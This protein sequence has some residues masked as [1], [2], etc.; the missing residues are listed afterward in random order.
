M[1]NKKIFGEKSID[2]K[3][4]LI[5]VLILAFVLLELILT[6]K[7][8]ILINNLVNQSMQKIQTDFF[9]TFS[10]IISGIFDI[11][12]VI[13]ITLVFSIYLFLTKRKKESIIFFLIVGLSSV[14][15]S[16]LKKIFSIAR[17]LNELVSATDFAFPSGHTSIVVVLFGLFAYFY[18]KDSK[19]NKT[20]AIF[21]SIIGIIIVAFSRLYL[22]V[23][24][25]TDII[26]GIII[27]SI[28]L[29]FALYLLKKEFNYKNLAYS[30]G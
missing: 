18:M 17:P 10:K 3:L 21:T 13:L 15:V 25:F 8:T 27:G 28:W 29:V 9:I 11:S 26:G 16:I 4:I 14:S 12:G 6:N 2:K 7:Y 23:H 24:W 5:L 30:R 20:L 22:S 19:K 1:I